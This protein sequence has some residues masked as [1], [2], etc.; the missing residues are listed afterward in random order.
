MGWLLEFAFDVFGD[1]GV[2][3]TGLVTLVIALILD[4]RSGGRV[5][6]FIDGFIESISGRR[7][8]G[9]LIERGR[10]TLRRVIGFTP[11]KAY[12]RLS[13]QPLL[14]P[15]QD[16]LEER[17]EPSTP[18][19]LLKPQYGVVDFVD[20]SD[21]RKRMLDW[22]VENERDAAGKL[23]HGPGGMGKTRLMIAVA[24][25]LRDQ[26]QWEAGFLAPVPLG[27]S[28]DTSPFWAAFDHLLTKGTGK[29]LL[30]VVDYA[31][32]RREDI[33][34]LSIRIIRGARQ[35]RPV[36]LVL[37]S[38]ASNW[39]EGLCAEPLTGH[40]PG[41]E[42]VDVLFKNGPDLIDAI[43]M[44]AVDTGANRRHLFDQ[45]LS[46]LANKMVDLGYDRPAMLP[47][48][49]AYLELEENPDYA[50]PLALQIRA[51]L[52]LAQAPGEDARDGLPGIL[53][54]MLAVEKAHWTRAR[55][56]DPEAPN[57]L[58]LE[59][60]LAQLT[61]LEGVA[62]RSDALALIEQ[63][64]YRRMAGLPL[65]LEDLMALYGQGAEGVSGLEPDIIGE[66]LVASLPDAAPVVEACLDWIEKR[67]GNG[68]SARRQK[69]LTVLQRAGQ[70]PT[71]GH[72]SFERVR[73]LMAAVLPA[74]F[75][76]LAPDAVT[77]MTGTP[78]PL[79]ETILQSGVCVSDATARAL[80]PLLDIN[81][82]SNQA[83]GELAL[84]WAQQC[85]I[86]VQA[87]D[88]EGESET[89]QSEIAYA[90]NSA[91]VWL[92]TL[93]RREA[94][95]GATQQAVEIRHRLATAN[96][97][98]FE[99]DLARSLNN[100]GSQLS[101]LGQREAALGPTQQ[102]MEIRHR[103]ATANPD[104]F[105]SDLAR[106]L[107]N[108]GIRLSDLGRREAAL[109]ATQQAVEIRHR[110]AAQNPDAFTPDLAM[111]LTNL[112][113]QLSALGRREESLAATQEAF[114]LYHR[115]AAQNPQAFT[116]DL[117]MSQNNLGIRLSSQGRREE[118]LAASQEA[119]EIGRRLAAQNP[120]A[121]TPDLARSLWALSGYV[122]G[123][124][125][126]H[127]EAEGAAREGL[128]LIAPYVEALPAAH[129][130]T[131]RG[132]LTTYREQCEKA[133]LA[134]DED[135][136]RRIEKALKE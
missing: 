74:R 5:L 42:A 35:G 80:L 132:L 75:E 29:G 76:A 21:M 93:G 66:H 71:H 134:L 65:P 58:A 31:E 95:L 110:L 15:K 90:L 129:G 2:W 128:D 32:N 69:V 53:T 72:A 127:E 79:A 92:S 106:S 96:P 104:V 73:S 61:L 41:G 89:A 50:R 26:H 38:R 52:H 118:A 44:A 98:A 39:L 112:G 107:N 57:G 88:G 94:A 8:F 12:E 82:R 33:K 43:E 125:E 135:L 47:P 119:V 20:V 22:C 86:A 37:L 117:A 23:V 30:I 101:A 83:Y 59:R 124:L 91:G 18:A 109:G 40:A 131:A 19:T 121:F 60:A 17:K 136:V 36:R 46:Q 133:G 10:D 103:L 56:I 100:L 55:G 49:A 102:A 78:G 105:E 111:S 81:L 48:A 24:A 3:I 4:A 25:E 113:S 120:Q 28:E 13:G 14:D 77:A 6:N 126:R 115:L 122:L 54:K 45:A 116:P 70:S 85:V 130:D 114:R 62:T 27:T 67:P 11:L 1:L 68:I 97:D 108:L 64:A 9:P 7:V 84:K 16:T 51:L 87:Q 34:E 99:P 123:P 63:D